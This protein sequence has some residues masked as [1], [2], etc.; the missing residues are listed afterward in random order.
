M[1]KKK[2]SV[3]KKRQVVLDRGGGLLCRK[4][5]TRCQQMLRTVR[6]AFGLAPMSSVLPKGSAERKNLEEMEAAISLVPRAHWKK[7]LQD[8]NWDKKRFHVAVLRKLHEM[9]AKKRRS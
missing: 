8:D 4:C 9:D 1:T 3:C 2:C 7:S 6:V 5:S